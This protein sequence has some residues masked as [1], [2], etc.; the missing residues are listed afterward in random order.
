MIDLRSAPPAR[1]YAYATTVCKTALLRAGLELDTARVCELPKHT[2]VRCVAR[3]TTE[4]GV[5]R[6]RVETEDGRDGWLSARFLAARAAART[7]RILGAR[8]GAARRHCPMSR[9][10]RYEDVEVIQVHEANTL[11][12]HVLSDLH[13]DR[14]SQLD[15]LR[16]HL[17]R[18]EGFYDVLLCA[19]DV[20]NDDDRFDATL[21]VL[22]EAYDAVAREKDEKAVKEMA[23]AHGEKMRELAKER[24]VECSG[25]RAT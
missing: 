19:G 5:A 21:Q 22:M 6:A 7:H 17:P 8:R 18:Q 2:P 13:S 25:R 3:G 23:Q 1:P 9:G 15:W 24:G 10:A 4:N 11:R 20:T 12:L 14:P 16:R